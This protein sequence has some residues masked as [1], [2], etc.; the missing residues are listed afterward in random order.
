MTIETFETA[1][2]I[3]NPQPPTWVAVIHDDDSTVLHTSSGH[4]SKQDA[5]A[6]V[7]RQHTRG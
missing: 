1:G 6:A 7:T 5:I 2:H 3:T 4:G